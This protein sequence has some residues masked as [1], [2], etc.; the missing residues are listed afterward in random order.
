M[1]QF[2]HLHTHSD[3][4]LLKGAAPVKALVTR[5]VELGMKH[6]ALTDDGNMFGA[7]EFYKLCR[8]RGI[9]PIVG[10]DAYVAARSRTIRSTHDSENRVDRLVLLAADRR[11]YKNLIKLSSKA[12]TEGFYYKPRIDHELLARHNEGL[13]ALSGTLSGEVPRLLRQNRIDDARIAALRYRDL[14]G[15]SGFYLELQDHGLPEQRVVNQGLV[16]LSDQTGIP[17]V[18]SNDVHYVDRADANAQDILMCIGSNKKK[19]DTNRFRYSSD[20]FYLKSPAEMQSLFAALPQA[21]E[22]SVA[23]AERCALKIDLPGPRFPDYAIPEQFASGDDYLRHLTRTGL[24]ARYSTVGQEIRAR[25]DYELDTIITMGFTGYFLIVWDFIKFARDNGVPVG[26]GRGSGAGSIVAYSLGI[27]DIDPLRYGLLFERFLNPDRISMP[28]FDID[29]CYERRG[30]V[31]DYVHRKYG[32]ERV[33]Q[34]ITFGTLKAKAV[35][36]DVARVLDIPYAEADTIAKLVPGG[37]KVKL[38]EAIESEP[39]LQALSERGGVYR[40]LIEVSLKLEGLHRHASTHAAGIVIGQQELTEYVPLYRD[41]RT[42]SISTQY[43]MDQLEGCGL[44]KMDFLGLK[45]LTLI[46][47]TRELVRSDGVELDMD[48]I[49]END[50]ATFA[51]LGEGKSAAVF[52]FESRGM[53]SILVKAKPERIEDLIA[54][55]ALYRPGPM[56][57]IDQFVDSKNGRTALRYPLPQLEPVLRETYGVI[58]YQEQVMEIVRIVGG[59]SLGQADILRRAMGKKKEAEMERM[60][61]QFVAGALERGFTESQAESIFTLLKPFAGYG[62]NKSHAAAYSVLAYKTAYLKANYPVQFMAANLT[63]EINNSRNF[64]WYMEEAQSMGIHVRPPDINLSRKFFSVLGREIIYGL[65]GIKNVGAAAVDEIVRERGAGGEFDSF[66]GFLERVDLKTVNRKVVEVLIQSGAF[67]GLDARRATLFHNLGR[68]LDMAAEAREHRLSGQVS[69]FDADDHALALALEEVPEWETVQRLSY[70]RD[71]LGFYF[72][73]NPL[74]D[75]RDIWKRTVTIDLGDTSE[76]VID[77]K[78][79]LLGLLKS[80]R[81]VQT[82]TGGTMAFGVIEDYNGSIEIVFFGEVW[83]QCRHR[84]EENSVVAL[85]GK[86]EYRRDKLQVVVQEL[87][88]PDQLDEID[89]GEVHIRLDE[90]LEDP[91]AL[92]QLRAFLHERAGH[93]PVF[94]HVGHN[95]EEAVIRAS[96]QLTVSSHSEVLEDIRHYPHVR[97]VWKQ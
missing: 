77:R 53:Q 56:E 43:T 22:N 7:L 82:R 60:K 70:E 44:V 16:Q 78:Y 79:N 83:E 89:G 19:L 1:A 57:N 76:A 30:E 46:E 32:A 61:Q 28:D 66:E 41:P 4:S 50:P 36:R 47:R 31:I 88:E 6:L 71:N 13:I 86:L 20:Q 63:N 69:L 25:A 95:G 81:V 34:I 23:I 85:I 58:V 96:A 33:G 24:A 93:C 94:L 45:T 64:A 37:P 21:L 84:V 38:R 3:Y 29:F 40:E 74:D 80:L 12:Y 73:G 39:E 90:E 51:L 9:H 91:E 52:Q 2:A 49:E 11:G 92:K 14:F 8:S 59:F 48:A 35:I 10:M 67:D 42:G 17:L 54:L 15:R 65:I 97:D 18:A 27:T 5:A 55:N 62:F 72:S 75:F 87:R 68:C 26:P